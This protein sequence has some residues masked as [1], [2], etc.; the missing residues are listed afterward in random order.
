[1][2]VV[3][4]LRFEV[5]CSSEEQAFEV[6]HNVVHSIQEL[7]IRT[8]DEVCGAQVADDEWLQ[9]DRIEVDLGELGAAFRHRALAALFGERLKN[10]VLKRRGERR[11]GIR[12]LSTQGARLALFAHLAEHG[13]LPWWAGGDAG[14]LDALTEEVSLRDPEQLRA[15]LYA[16]RDNGVIWRRLAFQLDAVATLRIISLF[17]QLSAAHHMLVDRLTT[18]LSKADAKP[19]MTATEPLKAAIS[20][21]RSVLVYHAPDIFQREARSTPAAKA[22]DEA[23]RHGI[24]A[25]SGRNVGLARLVAPDTPE[26]ALNAASSA[27]ALDFVRDPRWQRGGGVRNADAA[28]ASG[29]E[30]HV[31]RHAGMVLVAPFLP[32][33]FAACEL[34]DGPRWRSKAAQYEAV[35]LLAYVCAG[36]PRLR[37]HD[38][39][40]HKLCCGIAVEEPVPREVD[41]RAEHLAEARQLLASVI[42]HWK[43]LKNTSIEGLRET[44][45]NRD[46]VITRVADGDWVLRIERKTLDVLIGMV[47]WGYSVV[48][49]PWNPY[50]IHVEW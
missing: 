25:A 7:A 31:V 38:L 33:F 8:I 42:E 49:M 30:R 11:P 19:D 35:H 5:R 20:K 13:T 37:E 36:A 4:R 12:S 23:L 43:A 6:R 32:A 9:I 2:H 21:A 3:D 10:E 41:L 26:E 47:P 15:F 44:F 18:A 16:R 29:E 17:E 34:L 28:A 50:R 24:A 22:L 27:A 39:T 14:D 46:G 1:M 40:L 45:L 48:A